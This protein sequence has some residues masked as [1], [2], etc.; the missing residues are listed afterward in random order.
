MTGIYGFPV[1]MRGNILA[2]TTLKIK[3]SINQIAFVYDGYS[4]DF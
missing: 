4:V 1:G 3:K 2:S